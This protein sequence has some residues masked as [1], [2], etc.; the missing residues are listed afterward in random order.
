MYREG[1][2]ECA[3]NATAATDLTQSRYVDRRSS[4]ANATEA[5]GAYNYDA[6]SN[7]A[8]L[9]LPSSYSESWATPGPVVTT[10]GFANLLSYSSSFNT[11]HIAPML[12]AIG[13]AWAPGS[14]EP[15]TIWSDLAATEQAEYGA[16]SESGGEAS[17]EE[18]GGTVVW[19]E[20]DVSLRQRLQ[21]ISASGYSWVDRKSVV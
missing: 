11:A 4:N 5:N 9:M 6:I 19:Y 7:S 15:S 10:G 20:N 13:Q 12:G 16:Q 1:G 18:P 3:S 17:Y 8:D 21:A 14:S 2:N